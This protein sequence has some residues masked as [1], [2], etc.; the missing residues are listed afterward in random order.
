M[1]NRQTT[2][3]NGQRVVKAQKHHK[4]L[5]QHFSQHAGSRESGY[6]EVS[7]SGPF[8]WPGYEQTNQEMGK[9]YERQFT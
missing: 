9:G 1:S 8:G 4:P 5:V 3:L 7:L 2:Q 6:I